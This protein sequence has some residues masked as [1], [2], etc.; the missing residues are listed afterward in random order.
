MAN[1]VYRAVFASKVGRTES[2]PFRK[3]L[4]DVHNPVLLWLMKS[5]LPNHLTKNTCDGNIFLLKKDV[6]FRGKATPT[7]AK[8]TEEKGE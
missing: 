7:I 4:G 5:R 8:K 2:Y 1:D 6:V 3:K